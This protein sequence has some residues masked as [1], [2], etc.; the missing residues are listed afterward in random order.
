MFF[1]IEGVS[2]VWQGEETL[3]RAIKIRVFGIKNASFIWVYLVAQWWRICLQCR[4][5]RTHGFD[6]WV[7]KTP[8]RRKW[9]PT[10]V[11]LPGKSHEQRSLAG[12]SPWGHKRVGQ[13]FSNS[14]I[15]WRVLDRF[16]EVSCHCRA[17]RLWRF[18]QARAFLGEVGAQEAQMHSLA[19]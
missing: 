19:W 5:P 17:K 6:P 15:W 16:W 12:Y 1:Q 11:F 4:Q 2:Q 7:G 8:W 13:F 3:R 9:R 14:F 18:L 10:P